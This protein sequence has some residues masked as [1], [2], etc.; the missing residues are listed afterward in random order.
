[1]TLRNSVGA[2][3]IAV[4]G[5]ALVA[6]GKPQTAQP[7]QSSQVAWQSPQLP[8]EPVLEPEA[9]ELLQAMS[10]RLAAA[11]TMSFTALSTYESPARTGHPLAYTTL[12]QVT[13]QRPDKL[14]VIT[15]AD[16]SPSELYYDGKVMTAYSPE[17]RLVA[18][19]DA[20]ST[21]DAMLKVAY[22]KAALYFPFTDVIVA[23]P[24]RD[25]AAGLKL[26]FVIGQ[27]RVVGG[28]RTDMVAIANDVLQAEFWI[29][30]DDHL[31]RMIRATFFDEPGNYRHV[32][33]FSNW[34]LNPAIAPGTFAATRAAGARRIEFAR[35]D[36]V[37]AQQQPAR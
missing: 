12:S 20:P 2:V 18:V 34:R 36:A 28:T 14:R 3:C 8:S 21:I 1:M 22:D 26:A 23:D 37:G 15:P 5:V 6:C 31:P 10:A 17:T 9:L 13:L 27:S 30:A 29:G 11:R 32:V 24:Y 25:L 19:T 4:L 16:G 7:T 35:P 33:E